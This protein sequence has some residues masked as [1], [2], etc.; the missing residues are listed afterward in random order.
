MKQKIETVELYADA[1]RE[2]VNARVWAKDESPAALL[3]LNSENDWSFICVAM[4]IVGD[5]SL[6]L[7]NFERFA[8]EGPTKYESS[9]EKYLRLYGV[10][11]AAYIQQQAALK[12]Y[13]L[14]NCSGPNR[15]KQKFDTL[16]IRVMRHKLASH[17]LDY[18]DANSDTPSAYVPVR[19]DLGGYTCTVTE[20]RGDTSESV[21][22]QAAINEHCDAVISVLDRTYE[23]SVRTLFKGQS[24]R[25]SEFTQKLDEM[26]QVRD[27]AVII[28]I[29][30]AAG[31]SG[32]SR[33]VIPPKK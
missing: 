31:S 17:G 5:T 13:A 4:D 8:L 24:K 18:L 6:A 28:R 20:N 15:E 11:S 22:L 1:F 29:P 19:I 27:G 30:G 12:L 32:I 14:M 9:G 7:H 2:L 25:I 26:R 10:L 21:D 3:R 23:K 33:I 16:Q